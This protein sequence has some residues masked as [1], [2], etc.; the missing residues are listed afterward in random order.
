MLLLKTSEASDN[1]K[2]STSTNDSQK[3]LCDENL[4]DSLDFL[5]FRVALLDNVPFLSG[6]KIA[7]LTDFAA[8][9]KIEHIYL[10]EFNKKCQEHLGLNKCNEIWDK[11]F[12]ETK[13]KKLRSRSLSN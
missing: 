5:Y 8:R 13:I 2:N 10:K 3:F 4:G 9:L 6:Y 1:S 7:S 12:E 11:V